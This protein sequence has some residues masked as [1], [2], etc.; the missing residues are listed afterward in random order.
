MWRDGDMIEGGER[1]SVMG[2]IENSECYV[3]LCLGNFREDYH[4]CTKR[5]YRRFLLLSM[6]MSI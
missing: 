1:G 6:L 3:S 4:K 5:P 2:H